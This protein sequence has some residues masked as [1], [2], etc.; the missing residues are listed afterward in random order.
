MTAKTSKALQKKKEIQEKIEKMNK[1]IK[2]LEIKSQQEIGKF[3]LKE[4]EIDDDVDSDILFEIIRS[5]S[6]D[7]KRRLSGNEFVEEKGKQEES[8]THQTL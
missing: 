1:E 7:V 4:W 5:Y 3:I 8:D 2:S 6:E